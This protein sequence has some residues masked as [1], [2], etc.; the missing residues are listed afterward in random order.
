MAVPQQV[1]KQAEQSEQLAIEHGLKEGQGNEEEGV[2]AVK[3]IPASPAEVTDPPAENWET[4]FKNYKAS[5]DETIRELRGDLSVSQ[6]QITQ[7]QQQVQE[8][9]AKAQEQKP[10][11]NS[12]DDPSK[13]NNGE[14]DL[15]SLPADMREKYEDEF[16]LSMS[17]MNKVQ[18]TGII[19]DLQKRLDNLE[20]S[21]D[22][23][24]TTQA[25][26]ARDLYYDELDDKEPNW[27]L[28]GAEQGLTK[29]LLEPVS[30]FDQRPLKVIFDEADANN[31][32]KTVLKILAAYKKTGAVDPGVN[33]PQ[34]NPNAL[35]ELVSPEV[36]NVSGSVIDDIGV[37]TE[38]FTESQVM[39][40]Y[41]DVTKNDY[42]AEDAA[43]IE[44]KIIK[45]PTKESQSQVLQSSKLSPSPVL[46]SFSG[47]Q[48]QHHTALHHPHS[49]RCINHKAGL[50]KPEALHPNPGDAHLFRHDLHGS[51]HANPLK[52][53]KIPS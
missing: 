31:D 52:T 35:D 46:F 8:L 48:R 9:I 50:L 4:R 21:I 44:S 10:A 29:Y 30:E 6:Q 41:S 39:K 14:F 1:R 18:M 26:S 7:S 34:D 45:T 22:T 27:E 11:L 13:I 37:H 24:Q 32:A 33:N 53:K 15:D 12:E 2:K 17:K 3:A 42:S 43:A 47:L 51:H 25:K 23:V 20:G 19:G 16:L 38:S 40:F 36:G 5:T 28:I 49:H